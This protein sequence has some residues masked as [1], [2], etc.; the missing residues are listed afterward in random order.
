M[1]FEPQRMVT[2]DLG[3]AHPFDRTVLCPFE[4]HQQLFPIDRHS[5]KNRRHRRKNALGAFMQGAQSIDDLVVVVRVG[6]I[7]TNSAP[8]DISH[9]PCR[10]QGLQVDIQFLET[11][12]GRNKGIIFLTLS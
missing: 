6:M 3:V 2:F 4:R 10:N 9:L 11:I 7:V 1:Q 8:G 5:R 12:V